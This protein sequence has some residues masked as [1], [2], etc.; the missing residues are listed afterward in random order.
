[1]AL[2]NNTVSTKDG[3]S[4]SNLPTD[5]IKSNQ[6]SIYKISELTGGKDTEI[7]YKSSGTVRYPFITT[8]CVML[9]KL[10]LYSG[11]DTTEYTL[12][13]KNAIQK[14]QESEP[15]LAK[16][17]ATGTLNDNTLKY[18][19]KAAQEAAPSNIGGDS[20][21]N[22]ND[23][24]GSDTSSADIIA[25]YDSYFDQRNQKRFRKNRS[26]IKIIL[27]DGT[28]TKTIKDVYMRSVS[29]EVDASGNPISEVYE[30]V[31]RDVIE[32]D[33][34]LDKG[35]YTTLKDF[36][37]A[38]FVYNYD[39][40]GYGTPN[41][42][43]ASEENVEII[44]IDDVASNGTPLSGSGYNFQ[45]YKAPDDFGFF[46]GSD[47]QDGQ[48]DNDGIYQK[49]GIADQ[50]G[51][52]NAWDIGLPYNK[53]G[54]LGLTDNDE[55]WVAT[56]DGNVL[57]MSMKANDAVLKTDTD[58]VHAVLMPN[59]N[60][61]YWYTGSTFDL[62]GEQ[63]II[64]N[65]GELLEYYTREDYYKF[66]AGTDLK[67]NKKPFETNDIVKIILP[68][69]NTNPYSDPLDPEY[70]TNSYMQ[71]ARVGDT[72][73]RDDGREFF[74]NS[75]GECVEVTSKDAALKLGMSEDE[76]DAMKN[77]KPRTSKRAK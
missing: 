48:F 39:Y 62:Y 14:F 17:N 71:Y 66:M 20:D 45:G 49:V 56:A 60:Y 5:I 37:G 27:G 43:A 52:V 32:T 4:G 28:I 8:V 6:K 7:S 44:D 15:K 63:V 54:E 41:Y 47:I 26:D 68:G 23:T 53:D 55:Y 11:E 64:G 67:G 51:N 69:I 40:S 36:A 10:G 1:M 31:A 65:N 16:R 21:D 25:H 75:Y 38:D 24:N 12:E 74:I 58:K 57:H 35:K 77:S 72:I 46:Y 9:R 50:N 13:I 73:H 19:Y 61:E 30:F 18:L 22:S 42:S 2:F 29:V 33:E 70:D 3:T 59:G 76:W 34:P